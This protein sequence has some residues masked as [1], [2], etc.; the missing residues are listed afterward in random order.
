[1]KFNCLGW[2]H[3]KGDFEGTAYNNLTLFGVARMEQKETQ[4]GAAGVDMKCDI[5]L[6]QKLQSIDFGGVVMCDVITETRAIGKGG[7]AEIVI[8]IVPLKQGS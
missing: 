6:L 1:M 3:S 2:K 5:S 8:D 7:H 4:R